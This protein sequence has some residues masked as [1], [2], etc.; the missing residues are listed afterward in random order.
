MPRASERP[1]A[2]YRRAAGLDLQ[3]AAAR[4]GISSR[5]LRQLET[6]RVPLS[7][8]IAA[9][10]SAEY[11]VPLQ[12]LTLATRAGGTGKGGGGERKRRLHPL[13]TERISGDSD[14]RTPPGD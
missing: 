8:R 9:R 12:A 1:F 5:Y 3:L 2:N 10:M 4:L 6:S 13:S 7:Q 11:G 14:V